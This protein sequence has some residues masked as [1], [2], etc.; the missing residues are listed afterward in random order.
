M[1]NKGPQLLAAYVIHPLLIM[2]RSQ[3]KYDKRLRFTSVKDGRSMC[4]RKDTRFY[5][6]RPDLCKRPVI[7]PPILLK[8]RVAEYLFLQLF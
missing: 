6:Y 2:R 4:S 8:D 3:G 7:Y 5:G 1:K